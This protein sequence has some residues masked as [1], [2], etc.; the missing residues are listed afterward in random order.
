MPA[1]SPEAKA[2]HRQYLLD[3]Y[4]WYRD[5]GICTNCKRRYAEPGKTLC[6]DCKREK[7]AKADRRDPGREKRRDYNREWRKQKIA[8][9]LCINCGKR[10]AVEGH[11]RCS[12]CTRKKRES[13]QVRRIGKRIKAQNEAR[14]RNC[15]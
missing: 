11:T 10:D 4:R 15:H 5:N 2:R 7:A 1:T 9:G 8:E 12:I 13:D 14:M 3:L 6:T